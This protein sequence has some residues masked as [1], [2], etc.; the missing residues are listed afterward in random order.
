MDEFQVYR[1]FP[2]NKWKRSGPLEVLRGCGL[3]RRR[4]A[5]SFCFIARISGHVE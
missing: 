4:E 2:M 1:R 5:P 3:G